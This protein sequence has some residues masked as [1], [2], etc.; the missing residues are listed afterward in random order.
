MVLFSTYIKTYIIYFELISPFFPIFGPKWNFIRL[1]PE[2]NKL[3]MY[4]EL[5]FSLRSRKTWKL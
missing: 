3:Y 2:L 4:A 1:V 5:A